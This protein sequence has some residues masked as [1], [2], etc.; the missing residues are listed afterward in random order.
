MTK[1]EILNYLKLHAFIKVNTKT[2]N[3]GWITLIIKLG[4]K[5]QKKLSK[6]DLIL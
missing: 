3:Y 6:T 1:K 4:D 2:N 5:V